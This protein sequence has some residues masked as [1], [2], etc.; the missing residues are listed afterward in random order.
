MGLLLMMGLTPLLISFDDLANSVE[1]RADLQERVRLLDLVW[2]LAAT[3]AR[4]G[5]C[6]GSRKFSVFFRHQ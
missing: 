4:R 5:N 3:V 6:S 2:G 1:Q